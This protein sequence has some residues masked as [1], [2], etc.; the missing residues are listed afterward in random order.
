MGRSGENEMKKPEVQKVRSAMLPCVFVGCLLVIWLGTTAISAPAASGQP[1]PSEL[2]I[3][4]AT[5]AAVTPPVK[6][7]VPT[8]DGPCSIGSSYPQSIQRWC[9]LIITYAEQNGL[10]A[11]L[12]A[13][14]MLQESGGDPQAY[15][16]SGAVGLLQV[17]PRD[18]IAANFTCSAGPCFAS[19]PT[20]NELQDPEYNLAY[21]THLL[22]SLIARYG[23]DRRDAL[24]AYGP[25]DAGYHYADTVLAIYE[26]YQ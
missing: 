15:S 24:K 9:G 23:G 6:A 2:A 7:V 21:G 20:R 4:T 10:P 22:A 18:G 16:A 11:N 17:M 13:A 19:R 5:A 3:E 25:M 26:R 1:S 12:I 8:A 14:V